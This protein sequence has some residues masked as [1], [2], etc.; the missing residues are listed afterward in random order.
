VTGTAIVARMSGGAGVEVDC[1]C[2]DPDAGGTGSPGTCSIV[3]SGSTLTCTNGTCKKT[4]GITV[5]IPSSGLAI[6]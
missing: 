6:A 5:T 1:D 2:T 3:V 4:C